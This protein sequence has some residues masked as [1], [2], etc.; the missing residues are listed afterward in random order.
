MSPIVY[1][2]PVFLFTVLV[3]GWI[4]SRR[5]AYDL[6]DA[7]SSLNLGILS[8]LTGAGAKLLSLGVYAIV[9]ESA[10]IATWPQGSLMAALAALVLYDF[11]Y[12][13]AHRMGH[14]VAVLWAAHV[15]HHSSECFNLSTA[16]RQTSSG[17]VLSWV[18]YLPMA[19]LG[20]PPTT[21]VVVG[22]IDLLYQYWVHTELVGRLGWIDRVLV[23]PSNHRVHHGQ[24][25]YC[26]DRNYGGILIIWD[27]LFGTFVDERPGETI[28]YGVRKPLHAYNPIWGN[29]HVYADLIG[30]S[31]RTQGL[32]DKLAVWFGPPG[33]GG[34]AGTPWSPATFARYGVE[35]SIALR[36][37]VIAQY[38][39]GNLALV[40][41]L[42]QLGAMG[43]FEALAWGV[44]IASSLLTQGGLLEG[45]AWAR[46]AETVRLA[47][48]AA[49]AL[50]PRVM[51]VALV[52]PWRI[53][54][55]IVSAASL[56]VLWRM[57][58]GPKVLLRASEPAT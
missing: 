8:Q 53:A 30:E 42:V 50:A 35:T 36:R 45:A 5:G 56:A 24:N 7:L 12:Y 34:R 14:E 37:Y 40:A 2:I 33:G 13:W 39:I 19:M 6:R 28:I 16:L 11:C 49:V 21:F 41:F 46:A 43:R 51:G 26:L 55:V 1:A 3:E 52:T 32:K 23:T 17:V 4:L 15:V 58:A 47:L 44:F 20:V 29:L 10:R 25:D 31:V 48:F 27:R 18:F 57:R 38:A 9:Y 22:L 54:W